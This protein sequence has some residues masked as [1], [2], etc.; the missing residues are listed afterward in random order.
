MCKLMYFSHWMQNWMQIVSPYFLPRPRKSC[1]KCLYYNAWS[2]VI[3]VNDNRFLPF[4]CVQNARLVTGRVSEASFSNPSSDIHR[5]YP[6]TSRF[7]EIRVLHFTFALHR[8]VEHEELI[9]R[10]GNKRPNV[11]SSFQLCFN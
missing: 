4:S 1:L 11:V 6:T 10:N 2:E 3:G 9:K 5:N 8:R 7:A